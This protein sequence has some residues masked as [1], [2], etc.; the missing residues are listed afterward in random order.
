MTKAE[1]MK[2]IADEVSEKGYKRLIEL[3]IEEIDKQI[4]N[5]AK[6]GNY[7]IEGTISKS[8]NANIFEHYVKNGY[9]VTSCDTETIHISWDI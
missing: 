7:S 9:R 4:L 3:T 2:Q 6:N 1:E 5:A 8:I